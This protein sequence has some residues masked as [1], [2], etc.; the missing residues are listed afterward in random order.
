[1]WEGEMGWGLV[2]TGLRFESQV[3]G[4]VSQIKGFRVESL[5]LYLNGC[6]Q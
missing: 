1:M 5:S 4:R 2:G 3:D 6:E